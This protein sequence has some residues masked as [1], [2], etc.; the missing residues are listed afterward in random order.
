MED[1]TGATT[2]ELAAASPSELV[3]QVNEAARNVS[4][5]PLVILLWLPVVTIPPA[6]LL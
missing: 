2:M 6:I 1:I 3:S 5:L 4:L